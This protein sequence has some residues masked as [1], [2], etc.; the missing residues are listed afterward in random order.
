MAYEL[1][2]LQML[3]HSKVIKESDNKKALLIHNK[4]RSYS[5]P[6]LH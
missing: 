6:N 5:K 2:L 1:W 4:Q 3:R